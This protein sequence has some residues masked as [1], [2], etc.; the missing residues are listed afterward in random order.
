M[1][2]EQAGLVV[3]PGKPFVAA[4]PDLMIKCECCG[5]GLVEIKC[6]YSIR[7][8]KPTVEKLTSQ[9]ISDGKA[10]LKKNSDY[11]F[12][13]QGQMGITGTKYT[14]L[15]TFTVHGHILE[16]ISVDK[17]FWEDLLRQME[18][19]WINHLG[20]EILTG[21]IGRRLMTQA[22]AASSSQSHAQIRA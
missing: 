10:S 8:V 19:F 11:F 2:S 3:L 22:V 17:I 18:W 4:S 6:P 1:K 5:E 15:Y 9:L 7:D 21:S 20:P 13:V 14:D 12:Q 16:R